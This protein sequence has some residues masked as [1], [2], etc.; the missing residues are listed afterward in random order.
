MSTSFLIRAGKVLGDLT[1]PQRSYLLQ[2]LTGRTSL[3]SSGFPYISERSF[4]LFLAHVPH[5]F[6]DGNRLLSW[7]AKVEKCVEKTKEF[8]QTE[9][10]SFSRSLQVLRTII[11]SAAVCAPP[12]LWILRHVLSV[13]SQLGITRLISTGAEINPDELAEK[14]NLDP[15]HLSWDFS[16]LH[17]RGYLQPTR[18]GYVIADSNQAIDIFRNITPI[19]IQFLRDMVDPLLAIL[20]SSRTQRDTNELVSFFLNYSGPQRKSK[21]WFASRYDLQVGYRLVPLVLA[22]HSM[23]IT[24]KL[25]EGSSLL[26][27]VPRLT[28]E[29]TQLLVNAGMI[30][31][32]NQLTSLGLRVLQRA[33]GPFGIIHAY[34]PYMQVL[35][36]KLTCKGSQT[37]VHRAKNIAASQD[38]NRKTFEMANDCYDQFC[39]DHNLRWSIFIEHALGQGEATRQRLQR[40][41]ENYIQY[42]G[43]DLEDAA[44]DKAEELQKQ[45]VLPK[46]MIFIRKADIANPQTVIEAV[47]HAGFSTQNSVMFVGNGFHEARSQTNQKI[48]D[49]FRQYCEAGILII[50]TEESALSDYDLVHTGWNTY[51]AGF[52]YVHELSGQGLRPVFGTDR[53]GRHSWKIC[54]ALGGY[55]VLSKYCAHTR[56]IYPFPKKGGYNP[57]ISMTY[58][59]VPDALARSLGYFPRDWSSASVR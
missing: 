18:K 31:G 32:K 14:L 33:P 4:R 28:P 9:R 46:N 23:K 57:P 36:D 8:S 29:M 5:L 56:T 35:N 24:K 43:A 54:A 25:E 59:C 40:E 12:D 45:N 48:V 2:I 42:F 16:L 15:K 53:F 6:A 10:E 44:I 50:F 51:H 55:A 11:Y 26:K 47:T 41:G 39:K 19:P 3:S 21:G 20:T 49:V 27:V 52:R 30:E 13:H 17:S 7:L 58:F 38:A 37:W 22:L 1:H 34:T